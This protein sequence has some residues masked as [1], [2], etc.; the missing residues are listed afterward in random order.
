MPR[1]LRW[2][3]VEHGQRLVLEHPTILLDVRA[4]Q[5]K[6]VALH[7]IHHLK[8]ACFDEFRYGL[9][10]PAH[11]HVLPE[12]IHDLAMHI[13]AERLHVRKPLAYE[14]HCR[15]VTHSPEELLEVHG[16]HRN[17]VF[18]AWDENVLYVLV[19]RYERTGL[20]VVVTSVRHKMLYRFAGARELLHFVKDDK[21]ISLYEL[22]MCDAFK[23]K[24]ES[25]QVIKILIEDPLQF[26]LRFTEIDKDIARIFVLGEFL[27]DVTF[28]HTT[29]TI[30]QKRRC[31]IAFR[32]PL[33]KTIV[34]FSLHLIS[35]LKTRE[36]YQTKATRSIASRTFS[37]AWNTLQPHIFKGMRHATTAHFQGYYIRALISDKSD[38]T[39][40]IVYV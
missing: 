8:I 12:H 14:R 34:D 4:I 13:R 40:H 15:H 28:P 7:R 5:G 9:R 22:G 29:G 36:F 24:E 33:Q 26:H 1:K 32:F 39:R 35:P 19:D 27:N 16:V 30:N 20:N 3:C 37:R 10:H 25:V 31:A 17:A 23:V 18:L 6:Y 38:F 21:G 2:N 11:D